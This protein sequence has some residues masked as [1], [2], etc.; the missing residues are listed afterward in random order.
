MVAEKII[1][2]VIV[3]PLWQT[4]PVSGALVLLVLRGLRSTGVEAADETGIS[5]PI[6]L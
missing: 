3:A 1:E 6:M 5:E 4:V 2:W